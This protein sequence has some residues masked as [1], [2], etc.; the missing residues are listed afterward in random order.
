MFIQIPP[1]PYQ[2]LIDFVNG[3]AIDSEH[4]LQQLIDS[5][6]NLFHRIWNPWFCTTQEVLDKF[7]THAVELF[8]AS[9]KTQD[10]IISMKPDY[11]PLVPPKEF[12]INPDW[13]VTIIE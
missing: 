7:G 9:K 4:Q 1:S 11:K 6:E 12:V 5:H 13:T 10:Y 8:I 3:I 2:Q